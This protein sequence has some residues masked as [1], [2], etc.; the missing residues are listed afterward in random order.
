MSFSS[1]NV[2]G[3]LKFVQS[4]RE[5]PVTITGK[6]YG[7]T[8]G[9]HGFHVHA[10]GDL[11]MGCT[12]TGDHFNPENVS[13]HSIHFPQHTLPT[14]AGLPFDCCAIINRLLHPSGKNVH[15]Q[16]KILSLAIP[17]L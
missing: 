5:G 17:I 8:E 10:K 11:S 13:S 6:I 14:A 4:P 16:Y 9:L 1:K 2:T 12:S 7:L 15:F 3:N